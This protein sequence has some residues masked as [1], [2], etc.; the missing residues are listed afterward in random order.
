MKTKAASCLLIN[1]RHPYVFFFFLYLQPR[2]LQSEN[3]QVA[4]AYR[5]VSQGKRI[6]EEAGRRQEAGG[7]RQRQIQTELTRPQ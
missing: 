6:Q 3:L 2:G 4:Y 7:R 1:Q 5:E